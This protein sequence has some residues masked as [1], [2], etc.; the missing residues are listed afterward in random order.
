[1]AFFF[2]RK[3]S[4]TQLPPE[5]LTPEELKTQFV[6][7]KE[8]NLFYEHVIQSA[9][10]FLKEFSFDLVELDAA[11]FKHDLEQLQTHIL[12]G[13]ISKKI[14]EM[15]DAS[16]ERIL[17]FIEAEKGYFND[18]ETELKQMIHIL[19]STLTD[20]IGESQTFSTKMYDSHIRIETMTHLDDI[21]KLKEALK[22]EASAM[23]RVIQAQQENERTRVDT[24]SKEVRLLKDDLEK[25]KGDSLRDGLT[26]ANNRLSFD[27]YL[28]KLVERSVVTRVT[29]SLLLCDID[30]FKRINDTYGHPIGDRVLMAFVQEARNMFRKD[31]FIARYG[32]EEFAILL[33]GASLKNAKKRATLFRKTI[34]SKQYVADVSRPDEKVQ[35]TV[36]IGV[37]EI[38]PG[39]TTECFIARV[40]KALYKAKHG[41]RNKVET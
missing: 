6:H 35:F 4:E 34:A 39:E 25:A 17:A 37:T 38:E 31:D 9:V 29:F 14:S 24:L 18:R 36:S 15:F 2:S 7:C 27:L 5:D 32:G 28:Q 41:G 20:M 19:R 23:K 8:Q 3:Q 22:T 11:R 33:N 10:Y 40:D 16:A 26:G 1:M 30:F 21:R 13:P 12:T